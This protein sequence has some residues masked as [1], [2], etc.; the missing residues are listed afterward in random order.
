[1]VE[2]YHYSCRGESHKASQKPC[3]DCSYSSLLED[4][5][6]MVIV[7]DGH[8]GNRYFRSDVGARIAT[9]VVSEYLTSFVRN[10][11]KS[12]FRKKPFTAKEA[13]SSMG[14][15]TSYTPIDAL[16]RQLFFMIV[17]QW[18]CRIADHAAETPVS[19]WEQ[20]NVPAG[21]LADLQNE[22]KLNSVYGCTL[23][24]YVQ[25]PEYWFA[26]HLGDGKCISFQ[27][28]PIWREPIPWDDQCFLNETT[29]LCDSDPINEFRYCYQGDGKF[30]IA[31]FI[32][33]DGMDDSYANIPDLASFYIGVLKMLVVQGREATIRSIEEDLPQLS[34]IGSRDDMS[35]AF[36]YNIDELKTKLPILIQFQIELVK[37]RILQEETESAWNRKSLGDKLQDRYNKLKEQWINALSIQYVEQKRKIM[38]LSEVIRE[39]VPVWGREVIATPNVFI[40]LMAKEAFEG[41]SQMMDIYNEILELGYA[42]KLLNLFGDNEW[43]SKLANYENALCGQINSSYDERDIRFVFHSIAKGVG[44]LNEPN[45]KNPLGNFDGLQLGEAIKRVVESEGLDVVRD[46]R[47]VNILDDNHAFMDSESAKHI[48]RVMIE[49]GY[50]NKLIDIGKWDKKSQSLYQ[51]FASVKEV[52]EEFRNGLDLEL[53]REVFQSVACGLGYL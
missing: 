28:T 8:G 17:N 23:I 7:C 20:S 39:V 9:E 5:T 26:F 6:V 46:F 27:D 49:Q 44:L 30:P 42:E 13:L 2:C 51:Q 32:G 38:E 47:L 3:Q 18:R 10:V 14:V 35:M 11:D 15:D 48:L 21:Y 40:H 52:K 45:R 19:V 29:S 53:V 25:T 37:Q 50:T 1:M 41:K 22:N 33:S 36:V 12:L 34:T 16:F 24:A 4:G 31:V 43:E